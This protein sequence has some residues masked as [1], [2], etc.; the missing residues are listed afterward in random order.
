MKHVLIEK[1]KINGIPRNE[2]LGL[3]STIKGP[4]P[5]MTRTLEN[6][7]ILRADYNSGPRTLED[8]GH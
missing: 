1:A 5:Q 3:W 7:G 6:P 8:P 4:R 2:D